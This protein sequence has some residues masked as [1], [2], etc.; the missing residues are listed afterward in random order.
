M[1]SYFVESLCKLL[2]ID[3]KLLI[4]IIAI[5]FNHSKAKMKKP[6]SNGKFR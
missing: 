1:K 4:L 5:L 6:A 3:V 2:I